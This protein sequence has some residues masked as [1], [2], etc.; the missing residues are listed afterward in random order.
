MP[1]PFFFFKKKVFI[2]NWREEHLFYNIVLVSA[3]NQH[4]SAIGL[5]MSLPS[6]T[7]LPPPT[8]LGCYRALGWVPWVIQQIPISY[9]FCIV[10][11][12][13]CYSIVCCTPNNQHLRLLVG[14]LPSCSNFLSLQ[15]PVDTCLGAFLS[16][17]LGS[18]A[19]LSPEMG[20]SVVWPVPS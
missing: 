10:Y 4:G 9:L 20:K 8:P 7:S 6:W 13:P 15:G 18:A 1:L 11:V 12:F 16:Q 17:Q 5:H 19:P 3:K 14:G 2:F